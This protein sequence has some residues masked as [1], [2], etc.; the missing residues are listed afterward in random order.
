VVEAV[1]LSGASVFLAWVTTT[2][3]GDPV[4]LGS[5]AGDGYGSGGARRQGTATGCCWLGAA[6]RCLHRCRQHGPDLG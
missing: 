2:V 4:W 3:A 5:M 1:E 6:A